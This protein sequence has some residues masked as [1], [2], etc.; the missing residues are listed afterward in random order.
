MMEAVISYET[1]VNCQATGKIIFIV[2]L[3]EAQFRYCISVF[4]FHKCDSIVVHFK[5]MF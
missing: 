3:V 1:S 4:Y 5:W 2:V